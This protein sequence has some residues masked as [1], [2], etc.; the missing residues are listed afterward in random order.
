MPEPVPTKGKPTL[1]RKEAQPAP[2][3]SQSSEGT[4]HQVRVR[5]YRRMK[6]QRVY[7]LTVELQ[8][9]SSKPAIA[10]RTTAPVSLRPCIPGAH[11]TPPELE[12]KSS[13]TEAKATFYVTPLARGW[14]P[15]ARLQLLQQ[16]RVLEEIRLPMKAARQ[17]MTWLLAALTVL[18]PAALLYLTRVINL[19]STGPQGGRT[20]SMERVQPGRLAGE[21]NQVPPAPADQRRDGGPPDVRP[22][23]EPLILG[24]ALLFA[25]AP[26]AQ[27]QEAQ[28]KG[29]G[30]D[31]P[32]QEAQPKGGEGDQPKGEGDAQPKGGGAFPGRAPNVQRDEGP[33]VEGL[34]TP[35]S[36]GPP[37]Q[38]PVERALRDN[39]PP[40]LPDIDSL[41]LRDLNFVP[42]L[43][44]AAQH[45]YDIAHALALD[46]LSFYIG[47]ILLGLT[48]LSWASHRPVRGRRT[49][50][51]QLPL[52][53]GF[54]STMEVVPVA[55]RAEP[56]ATVEPAG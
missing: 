25:Q 11:V 49:R 10:H 2:R 53:A 17:S 22:Q 32:K 54:V 27:P 7:P 9:T 40:I 47:L 42:A 29:G 52:G 26:Q 6:P 48:V 34:Q 31:Q 1:T 23:G 41:G 37:A 8:R 28:P 38:G 45:C 13:Q 14:L 33:A 3:E 39:L 56:P 50:T 21:P 24:G 15:D 43:A 18:I 35:A 46:H 19:S 36:A 20:R 51:V 30:G 4:P 44:S 55:R 12:L 5:F 16:G